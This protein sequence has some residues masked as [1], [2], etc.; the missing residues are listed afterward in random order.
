MKTILFGFLCWGFLHGGIL[1]PPGNASCYWSVS[2]LVSTETSHR[3]FSEDSLYMVEPKSCIC[4]S[5]VLTICVDQEGHCEWDME[6]KPAPS[7]HG[8]PVYSPIGS[9]TIDMLRL[10]AGD[11][12]AYPDSY[13]QRVCA[14]GGKVVDIGN[15][16]LSLRQPDEHSGDLSV[17][18][19]DTCRCV[20]L[21]SCLYDRNDVL[22]FKI[23]FQYRQM[24]GKSMMESASLSVFEPDHWVTETVSR[25]SLL[26]MPVKRN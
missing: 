23:V 19:L 20:I 8:K 22:K 14:Q 2:Y 26:L 4:D 1:F 7:E 18:L 25:F 10:M 11:A 17:T 6:M 9:F 24:E 5:N 3:R 13:V 15:G 21:G 12:T 16:I